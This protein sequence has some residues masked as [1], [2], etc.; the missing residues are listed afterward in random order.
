MALVALFCAADGIEGLY[1]VFVFDLCFHV[2]T[3]RIG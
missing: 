1:L 2:F 3:C